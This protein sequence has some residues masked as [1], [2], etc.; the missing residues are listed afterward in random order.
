MKKN[1]KIKIYG[2]HWVL[3]GL[4]VI[5]CFIVGFI[6]FPAFLTICAWNRI[7][8]ATSVFPVINIF[9][10]ILLW[11]IIATSIY[12][13]NKDRFTVLLNRSVGLTQEEMDEIA[14]EVRENALKKKMAKRNFG[15][16]KDKT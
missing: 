7:S 14:R 6:V 3:F 9:Q 16:K 1:N 4:F 13:F 8:A 15:N 2:Y 12:L 11:L 10:G 5:T